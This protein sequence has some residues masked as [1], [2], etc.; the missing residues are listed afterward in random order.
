[1]AFTGK[2]SYDNFSLIG[3]DV[4]DLVAL[5]GPTETPFLSLLSDPMNPAT[6]T[7]HQWTEESLGPDTIINSAAVNSATAATGILINGFGVQL[8]VGMIL[9]LESGT[10]GLN[11]LVRVTS[12]PGA[13]SILVARN[14]GGAVSSLAAGGTITVVGAAA[15]EGEDVATD[16]TR[17][18]VRRVNATQIFKKDI[19]ISGTDQAM[20][21]AP[22]QG[23]QFS[24]QAGL[25]L[26]ENLRDLE[27]T[28]IRGAMISSVGS[29]SVYR[30]M[31]GLEAFLTTINSTI[32]TSSF[33]AAPVTYVHDVWQSVYSAG[34]R[35]IDIILAGTAWKRA[36][37]G[38]RQSVLAVQQ[39][40]TGVSQLVNTWRGDFGDA[41]V[42][43][44]PWV[45]PYQFFLLSS[46]RIKVVPLRGR[47]F[48]TKRIGDTGDSVKGFCVGEYTLE[49]HQPGLMGQGHV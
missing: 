21:Y 34:A 19:I 24:H 2:A 12:V 1:M 6:S 13:N 29:S 17:K 18:T 14:Q 10:P 33:T 22:N 30:T 31:T 37:S 20:V 7:Y 5:L 40:E 38:A 32:V 26:R 43:L 8:Q 23:D 48:Q 42:V 41:N 15:L 36:I 11:E 35:D 45:N 16:V 44:S 27:K 25:R 47:S 4:S 28:V 49:V 9:Q 46:S 39:T 3:E